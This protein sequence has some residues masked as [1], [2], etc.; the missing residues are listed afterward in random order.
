MSDV[1]NDVSGFFFNLPVS[2][3][4]FPEIQAMRT[5]QANRMLFPPLFL[6]LGA[7]VAK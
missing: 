1:L 6:S 2:L 7:N 3:P 4:S 5:L